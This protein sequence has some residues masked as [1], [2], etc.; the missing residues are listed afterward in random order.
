MAEATAKTAAFFITGPDKAADVSRGRVPNY[1]R[2]QPSDDQAQ[3]PAV[4]YT[5]HRLVKQGS[6]VHLLTCSDGNATEYSEGLVAEVTTL[7]AGKFSVRSRNVSPGGTAEA[8]K[9]IS[10]EAASSDVVFFA[11]YREQAEAFLRELDLAYPGRPPGQRPIILLPEACSGLE[12]RWNSFRLYRTGPAD[13][14]ACINQL[15]ND[16]GLKRWR[17]QEESDHLPISMLY[18]HDAVQLI[19]RAIQA[20]LSA[21][22]RV[23]RTSV[24][25]KLRATVSI[26]ACGGY[27][28]QGGENLLSSYFVFKSTA[29][30][31]LPEAPAASSHEI[32]PV[33]IIRM[34]DVDTKK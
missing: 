28:F 16:P 3:A 27:S 6:G 20:C 32:H 26:G 23:S 21:R 9:A 1:I 24:L 29:A 25:E 13:T 15:E 12:T 18:G 5:I 19:S 7:L 11:G 8:A 14:T 33:E 17:R 10:H 34:Q 30:G 2:L 31:P 22:E 4:A